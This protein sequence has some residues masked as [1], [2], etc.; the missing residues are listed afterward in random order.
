MQRWLGFPPLSLYAFPPAHSSNNAPTT[1]NG[2]QVHAILACSHPHTAPHKAPPRCSPEPTQRQQHKLLA[3]THIPSNATG[4]DGQMGPPGQMFDEGVASLIFG[5]CTHWTRVLGHQGPHTYW[6]DLGK[7][8]QFPS[9][10][11]PGGVNSSIATWTALIGFSLG[12]NGRRC[13]GIHV[14]TTVP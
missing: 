3:N 6:L 8:S 10:P 2:P 9:G 11:A 12:H 4:M 5:T 13:A 14:T 1:Q 7:A